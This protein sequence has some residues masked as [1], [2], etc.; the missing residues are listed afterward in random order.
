MGREEMGA[1][2][3]RIP[4]AFW[5]GL[6]TQ[7]R[8]QEAEEPVFHLS[9]WVTG[10]LKNFA[11]FWTPWFPAIHRGQ[12]SRCKKQEP[13]PGNSSFNKV[14]PIHFNVLLWSPQ[15]WCAVYNYFCLLVVIFNGLLASQNWMLSGH[16][17][18][19]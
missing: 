13:P 12:G 11:L 14:S 6:D 4:A 18:N 1:Q 10:P 2:C 17:L 9:N 19:T 16:K 3:Y 8:S 15:V 5:W 7:R